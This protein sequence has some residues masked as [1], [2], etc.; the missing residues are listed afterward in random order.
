VTDFVKGY[1]IYRVL[2]DDKQKLPTG[3]LRAG[4]WVSKLIVDYNFSI[5]LGLPTG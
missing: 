2:F 4:F 5:T 1:V 3:L